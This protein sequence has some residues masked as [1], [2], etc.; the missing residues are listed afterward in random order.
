MSRIRVLG[1][2]GNRIEIDGIDAFDTSSMLDLKPEPVIVGGCVL[3]LS[4]GV[5][6]TARHHSDRQA[7]G[8]RRQADLVGASLK[9]DANWR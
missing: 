4:A 6:T 8:L 5:Q 2:A 9:L 3:N 1:V 7:Q